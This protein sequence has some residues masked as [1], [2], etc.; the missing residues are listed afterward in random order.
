MRFVAGEVREV[1]VVRTLPP[2]CLLEQVV[3]SPLEGLLKNP[4]AR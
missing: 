1:A 4:M 2:F 3:Y